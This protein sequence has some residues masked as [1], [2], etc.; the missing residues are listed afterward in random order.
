[1]LVL[2]PYEVVVWGADRNRPLHRIGVQAFG[3]DEAKEMGLADF[4]RASLSE[5][6]LRKVEHPS[7][8]K[9][10][11]VEVLSG[12]HLDPKKRQQ[13]LFE[14]LADACVGSPMSDIQGACVNLLL[15]SVQRRYLTLAEAGAR[16]D[17]L[18][19]RGKEALRRRFTGQVDE[20][21]PKPAH[22]IG[23]RLIG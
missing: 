2:A 17:E 11:R 10:E 20:R 1:M 21:D 7:L 8:P 5:Q 19:G 13:S 3:E 15:T 23:N 16:W 4:R 9:V 6:R 22:E 18:M 12:I 14:D